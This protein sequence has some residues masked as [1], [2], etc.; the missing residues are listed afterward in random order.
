MPELRKLHQKP[1]IVALGGL[2]GSGK[3]ELSD[4][5]VGS[6]GYRRVKFADPIK[7]M[8]EELIRYNTGPEAQIDEYTEGSLKEIPTNYLGGQSAR[9][10]MQTLGTEWGRQLID[11]D[12]WVDAAY[13]QINRLVNSNS[14]VVVDD[15]RFPNEL[16]MLNKL[17]ALTIW[18]EREGTIANT[19]HPSE[20]SVRRSDFS[21]LIEN[22]GTVE[23][24]ERSARELMIV[25]LDNF[26]NDWAWRY[27]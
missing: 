9:Y 17:G 2:A 13:R 11:P 12:I 19:D 14:S 10:A 18:I 6:L 25:N 23:D 3:T 24:L 4:Y 5:M 16:A 27:D 20:N 7:R 15:V 21:V 8:L 26:N 1:N 22:N